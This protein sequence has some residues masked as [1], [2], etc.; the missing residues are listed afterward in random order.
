MK[1]CL[2]EDPDFAEANLRMGFE[3]IVHAKLENKSFMPCVPYFMKSIA[4]C[5]DIHSEPYYY[6]GFAYYEELKND[7]AA[8]YLNKFIKFS[9]NDE[10]KFGKSY[11]EELYQAKEMVK[12]M[13]KKAN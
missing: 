13:K 1:Q 5:A 10:S 6:I 3:Y 7:S 12:S 11:N 4:S 2:E 9:S 8:K